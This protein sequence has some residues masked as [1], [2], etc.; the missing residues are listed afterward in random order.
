MEVKFYE[1]GEV[2]DALL[3]FAVI[4][5]RCRGKWI[6]CKHQERDTWEVPGGHRE[7][8][9]NIL[10][11]AKRELF[12]ETGAKAFDLRPVCVYSVEA[13]SESYGLLCFAE[14]TEL[15]EL[16]GFE[17]EKIEF[18]AETPGNLTYPLIQPKLMERIERVY[19]ASESEKFNQMADYYDQYRPGYPKE[20]VDT[21]IEKANLAAG[22]KV[23]EIG[24]GSGKATEQFAN[25]GFAIICVE[26]GTD[27]A[28][29][30][31]AR[32]QD[33]NIK[34]VVSRFEDYAA[35]FEY[36]DAVISAQAFHWVP[37][38]V[39]YEKCASTLKKSGTLALFWNLEIPCDI[40]LDRDL[41]A[42]LDQYNG[43]VAC[44]PEEDYKKRTEKISSGIAGSGFFSEP[45]LIQSHW[46]KTYTADEYFGFAM[47]SNAFVQLPEEEQ[48]KCHE[49]LMRLA[50]K[51]GGIR[52]HYICELYLAKLL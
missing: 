45:E 31:A 43:F 12:E 32:F 25:Y 35:P 13:G 46:E 8:N 29:K 15:G 30:G 34:Y 49:E 41:M 21:I 51:Y 48:R 42:I 14:I 39:G 40:D 52:R 6:F 47:T 33:K 17:I 38:P 10:D 24:A 18:F 19:W 9:E 7:G 50:A 26:P 1:T 11:T 5:S 28:R 44:V 16:P 4:V 27:L 37:Q 3:K 20:I 22:S 2:D 23:L 36:F